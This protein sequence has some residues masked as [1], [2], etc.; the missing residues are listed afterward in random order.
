MINCKEL[1]YF[2][3]S[4][5][6]IFKK[7]NISLGIR[8]NSNLIDVKDEYFLFFKMCK[9]V[10]DYF[11]MPFLMITSKGLCI[12]LLLLRFFRY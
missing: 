11:N 12:V 5:V 9:E 6:Y 1:F 2:L 10:C 7:Y 3:N 4:L 8:I